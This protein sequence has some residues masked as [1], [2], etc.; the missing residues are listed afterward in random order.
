[1]NNLP[2]KTKES[3]IDLNNTAVAI[4]AIITMAIFAIYKIHT[5]VKYNRETEISFDG[6]GYFHLIS[7]PVTIHNVSICPS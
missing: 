4:T 5:D 3:P 1:M 2:T 6:N 7:R